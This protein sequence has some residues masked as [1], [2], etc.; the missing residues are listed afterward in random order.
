MEPPQL[1]SQLHQDEAFNQLASRTQGARWQPTF[2]SRNT[3]SEVNVAKSMTI[4][5]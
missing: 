2:L 5:D 4:D 3:L 1:Y